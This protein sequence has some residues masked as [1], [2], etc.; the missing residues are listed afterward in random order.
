MT[1]F[2]VASKVYP[3]QCCLLATVMMD[4][5]ARGRPVPIPGSGDQLSVVA[6]AEAGLA[7]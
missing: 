1:S 3:W 4:R 7:F 5:I 6:H 2:N